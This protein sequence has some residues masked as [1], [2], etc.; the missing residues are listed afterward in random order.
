MDNYKLTDKCLICKNNL[1]LLLDLGNHPLANNYLKSENEEEQ[2]FPLQLCLCNYCFNSQINCFVN[3]EKLFENYLY[4]SGTTKTML[5]YFNNFAKKSL[6]SFID[7]NEIK[8]GDIKILEIACNDGSQLDAIS[9]LN[10]SSDIKIITVGVDPAINI[11]NNITSNKKNHDI[12]CEFFNTKTV[13]KLRDKYG[14]FDIIIAQNVFAHINYP[15]EFLTMIKELMNDNTRLYIQTSQ[16]NMILENQFDTIYHEHIN[17]FNTNSMKILCELNKLFLNNIEEAEVHGNSYIFI[18]SKQKSKNSNLNEVLEEEKNKGLYS[19][20]TYDLYKNNCNKYKKDF[21]EK[22]DKF[23]N[24]NKKIIAIGSSAKSMTIF[25]Y[26]NINN[27]HI[28]YIIDE[29]PLKQSLITPGSHIKVFPLE[30]LKNINKNTII[31]I[32]AWNFYEEIKEKIL[33]TIQ[34]YNISYNISLL[35]LN[36]LIEENI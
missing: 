21:L 3:P 4:V 31:I 9:N 19:L 20:E 36:T 28:D 23:K 35:N 22:I 33:K 26:C 29:N 6:F 10:V 27:N 30:E 25:N 24:E 5:D 1:N 15:H 11:Y 32:T 2:K 7:E 12:Y 13:S 18:I 8:K 34:Q 14:T 17:F 16:K